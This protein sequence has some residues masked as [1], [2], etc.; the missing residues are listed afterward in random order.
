MECRGWTHDF[1]VSIGQ[2]LSLSPPQNTPNVYS[3][4]THGQ[5]KTVSTSSIAIF[6]L[7]SQ[8][9]SL[10]GSLIWTPPC[11]L[12]SEAYPR[13]L[14]FYISHL[15]ELIKWSCKS[16]LLTFVSFSMGVAAPDPSTDHQNGVNQL[17]YENRIINPLPPCPRLTTPW[18][19]GWPTI[20]DDK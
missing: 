16:S 6:L 8:K 17:V 12:I 4:T 10:L 9:H 3:T 20:H 1:L 5:R 14:P 7:R 13:P 18:K 11:L 15:L 2:P 19:E